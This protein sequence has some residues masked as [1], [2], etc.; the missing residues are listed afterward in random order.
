MYVGFAAG[1]R[2]VESDHDFI[3][4]AFIIV[5]EFAVGDFAGPDT[6]QATDRFGMCRHVGNGKKGIATR[7]A[8]ISD[9]DGTCMTAH[10]FVET[11]SLCSAG[12]DLWQDDFDMF[13][14]LSPVSLNT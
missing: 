8:F 12:L 7:F 5:I 13:H 11:A 6:G 4:H 14:T 1:F 10:V 3:S 9:R 2:I